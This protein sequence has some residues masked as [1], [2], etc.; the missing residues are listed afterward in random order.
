MALDHIEVHRQNLDS[1]I[2]AI[3]QPVGSVHQSY[4]K[5][6]AGGRQFPWI[7]LGNPCTFR[8]RDQRTL[9][10]NSLCTSNA[11]T[12]TDTNEEQT[13]KAARIWEWWA[14]KG[15]NEDNPAQNAQRLTTMDD[16]TRWVRMN[17]DIR[18]DPAVIEADLRTATGEDRDNLLRAK[19]DRAVID[20]AYFRARSD[21]TGEAEARARYTAVPASIRSEAGASTPLAPLAPPPPPDPTPPPPPDPTPPPAPTTPTPDPDPPQTQQPQQPQPQNTQTASS[22][23]GGSSSGVAIAAAGAGAVGIGYLVWL[24]WPDS[25]VVPYAIGANDGHGYRFGVERHFGNHRLGIHHEPENEAS[26]VRWEFRW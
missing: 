1:A 14:F 7:K 5:P 21:A 20:I 13:R 9:G 17:D 11:P 18:S 24:F 2:Y 25:E 10:V 26:G 8:A 6:P 15:Q 19:R 22:G 12:R 23:G 4:S 16:L 3:Q